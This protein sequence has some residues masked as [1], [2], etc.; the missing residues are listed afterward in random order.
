LFEHSGAST[1]GNAALVV[2]E[3]VDG[4]ASTADASEIQVSVLTKDVLATD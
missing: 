4:D 1:G 3:L 2:D